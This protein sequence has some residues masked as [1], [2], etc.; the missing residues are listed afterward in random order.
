MVSEIVGFHR[1]NTI[2]WQYVTTDVA[3][4]REKQSKSVFSP[5]LLIQRS[6]LPG[7]KGLHMPDECDDMNGRTRSLG[8]SRSG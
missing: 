3:M 8:R 6:S 5:L 1:I 7:T 4:F 2:H